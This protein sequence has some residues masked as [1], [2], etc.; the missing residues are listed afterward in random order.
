[1]VAWGLFVWGELVGTDHEMGWAWTGL[2]GFCE[3]WTVATKI[4]ALIFD[5]DGTLTDSKPGIVGCLRKVLDARRIAHP[6]ALDRFVGPPVEEW[7]VELLPNGSEEDRIALADD[8]RGC[9]DR[10]GWKNNSVFP[11]VRAVLAELQSE[12]FPLYVCTSKQLRFAVRILDHFGLTPWFKAV[13]GDK[14][15]YA[16]HSKIDLLGRLIAEQGLDR[17]SAWMIGDRIFDIDA[18]HGNGVRCLFAGWGYGPAVEG[19]QAD[20]VAETAGDI[21]AIVATVGGSRNQGA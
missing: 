13:Y 9:Y 21:R 14:A 19:E 11:A 6:G 4:P 8:Y 7:A 10:E 5:L 17:H 2:C 3:T 18:A 15:E 20:A 12:G 16:S 1:M